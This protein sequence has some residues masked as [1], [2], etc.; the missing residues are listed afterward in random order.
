MGSADYELGFDSFYH[1]SIEKIS[2]IKEKEKISFDLDEYRYVL[3]KFCFGGEYGRLL[4][5]SAD[6]SDFTERFIV[7]EIDSIK[8]NRV[9]F[10]IV[11]LVIMD[12]VLQ[13]MR[14][15]TG[16]RKA[17]ILEEAWKAIASP[18]MANYIL[19]LYKTMRKF[20]GEPIIV[21]QELGD[22][23]GNAV[24]KDSILASSDTICLLDQSKFRGNY[25]E[26]AKLLALSEVEQRK[27]FTINSL[28][29]KA[30]RGK[31]KEVYIKRGSTGEVYGVEVSIFQYLTF[32]TEKPEKTAVEYYV[33]LYGSYPLG[34]EKFISD[35]QLSGL[36]LPEFVKKVN[37]PPIRLINQL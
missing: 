7:Y 12:L 27:I 33:N 29:N 24:I 2:Q 11:T 16:Q 25:S 35:M 3:K 26:V 6:A 21:T 9:L 8:E 13:K 23:I 5:E 20:W 4:N 17:M 36:S 1:Y 28:E 22:I 19:Y 30:G 10:P 31:F 34:L 37:S 18:L 32:T 15:R 14:H